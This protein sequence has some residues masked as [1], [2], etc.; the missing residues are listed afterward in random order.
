MH[1][2][3]SFQANHTGEKTH[4]SAV[5]GVSS[6]KWGVFASLMETNAPQQRGSCTVWGPRSRHTLEGQMTFSGHF[7]AAF[8]STTPRVN[9]HTS[10]CITKGQQWVFKR[11]LL[12]FLFQGNHYRCNNTIEGSSVDLCKFDCQSFH[13]MTDIWMRHQSPITVEGA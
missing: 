7:L 2:M 9:T 3:L 12:S 8:K 10:P 4:E 5:H 13:R 1:S 6:R 11:N